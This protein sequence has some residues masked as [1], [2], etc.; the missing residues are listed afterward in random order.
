MTSLE[1][2]LATACADLSEL[3]ARYA[4]VGGL[5][6]AVR[7]EPRLTRDADLVVAVDSDADAE[8]LIRR[9]VERGYR[10]IAT[11]EQQ[12]AGRLA[13]VRLTQETTDHAV[14]TDLLFASSGIEGE[15]VA[16]AE[17]IEILPGLTLPVAGIGH[18][19]A[20]KLLAHD[21]RHRPADADDL[22]A[23]SAVAVDTDWTTAHDAVSLITDRGF[24]RGRDL[25]AALEELRTR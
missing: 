9:L 13:T 12:A 8:L 14:V 4:L 5:A 11:V 21:D 6:V 22:R 16:D 18:L 17:P 20:M 10:V 7:S 1:R 2:S 24:A 3:E 25:A 23:L 15:I 19:M